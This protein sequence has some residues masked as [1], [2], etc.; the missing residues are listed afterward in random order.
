[1]HVYLNWYIY[2]LLLRRECCSFSNGEYVK[3]GLQYL[4]NWCSRETE[5]V[6]KLKINTSM[7]INFVYNNI[8][9]HNIV[10][11][12]VMARTEAHK[13][14]YWFSGNCEQFLPSSSL[15]II[16]FYT[17]MLLPNSNLNCRFFVKSP[18]KL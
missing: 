12:I 7:S 18:R 9:V 3:A 10:C 5:E 1:M 4:E 17:R 2:S 13:T 11:W 15:Y 8:L 6:L 14:G 16:F